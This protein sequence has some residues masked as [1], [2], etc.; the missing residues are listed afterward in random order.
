MHENVRRDPLLPLL[1]ATFSRRSS[2]IGF[3]S[4]PFAA[5]G[6]VFGTRSRR[7]TAR[8]RLV[9]VNETGFAVDRSRTPPWAC[10]IYRDAFG[11]GGRPTGSPE[12]QRVPTLEKRA[13]V[14]LNSCVSFSAR[15]AR[16]P[17]T[18]RFRQR[19]LT[20]PRGRTMAGRLL[21]STFTT[22]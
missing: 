21:G 22:V 13:P 2:P 1:R 4:F 14:P 9:P 5:P 6:V 15:G 10:F 18:S 11:S 12:R 20:G 3:L 17:V 19:F 16:A 8:F 7:C